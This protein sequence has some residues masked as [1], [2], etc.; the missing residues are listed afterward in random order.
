GRRATRSDTRTA[1]NA[2]TLG[3]VGTKGRPGAPKT[4]PARWRALSFPSSVAERGRRLK[5]LRRIHQS[6]ARGQ[7]R[8]GDAVLHADLL[9]QARLVGVDRLGAEL[10]PARDHFLAQALDQQHR[11]LQLARGQDIEWRTAA[12]DTGQGHVLGHAAAEVALA[13]GHVAYRAQQLARIAGLADIA[14]GADVEQ[15]L[16]QRSV[17]EHGYDQH[18]RRQALRDNALG[19][20]QA[21]DA[22]QVQVAE[23]HVRWHRHP[24]Q[25]AQRVLAIL[26]L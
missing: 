3:Q 21:A 13:V 26:G 8:E 23:D 9:E 20:F 5:R 22:R 10:E 4:K 17:L 15:P 1:H 12:L 16:R 2:L 14:G 18:A 19:H 6:V 7:S 25:L 24:A 11:H